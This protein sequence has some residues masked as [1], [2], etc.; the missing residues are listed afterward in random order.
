MSMGDRKVQAAAFQQ[1]KEGKY[2]CGDS[3]FYRETPDGFI[4]AIADGLGSGNLAKESSQIVIDVIQR[5]LETS[6]EDI[7]KKINKELAGKRGVLIGILK[8]NYKKEKYTFLSIGNIGLLS[9][10]GD[11]TKIR[12]ISNAGYLAGYQTDY[13]LEERDLVP[14]M[15]FIL[16]SD[17][18]TEKELS[19]NYMKNKNV[20][21]IIKIYSKLSEPNR[22]DDTTLIAMRYEKDG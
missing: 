17:G 6:P 2:I 12:S 13:K 10:Y 21:D 15:N 7:I 16:F 4:C 20:E 1:A 5:H 9:I 8:L 11:G 3:Y 14:A 19:E 18:V 22:K